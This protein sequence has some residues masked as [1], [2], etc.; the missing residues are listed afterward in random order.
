M[1]EISRNR[2]RT[3]RATRSGEYSRAGGNHFPEPRLRHQKLQN[4][5]VS[6]RAFG[7]PP[8]A[9]LAELSLT[10]K[11][12]PAGQGHDFLGWTIAAI[13]SLIGDHVHLQLAPVP[14][15]GTRRPAA[16][17]VQGTSLRESLAKRH[18]IRSITVWTEPD[19]ISSKT[20]R[21]LD[22]TANTGWCHGTYQSIQGFKCAS[23]SLP[24]LW[25]LGEPNERKQ[26]FGQEWTIKWSDAI[27]T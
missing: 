7:W 8:I 11:A 25:N 5:A 16:R 15:I 10:R 18:Q 27:P 21:A 4:L 22:T 1:A 17:A 13:M 2:R 3:V 24:E 20:F 19:Q 6:L 14:S 26:S 9:V 23:L 12:R